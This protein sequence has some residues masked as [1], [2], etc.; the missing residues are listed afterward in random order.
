MDAGDASDVAPI[1]DNACPVDSGCPEADAPPEDN[2]RADN[3]AVSAEDAHQAVEAACCCCPWTRLP[4]SVDEPP[5]GP[6]PGAHG[7]PKQA[8]LHLLRAP[9]HFVCVYMCVCV[10]ARAGHVGC[11]GAYCSWFSVHLAPM[12]PLGL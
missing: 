7:G 6:V 4:Q 9:A 12:Y 3:D 10:C 1:A 8:G 2:A 11:A 5:V